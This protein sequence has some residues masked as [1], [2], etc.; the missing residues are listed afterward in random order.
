MDA[1]DERLH[2]ATRMSGRRGVVRV[3]EIHETAAADA[4]EHGVEIEPPV[5]VHAYLHDGCAPFAR[6]IAR[7]LECWRGGQEA[8]VRGRER[9][10]H[11]LENLAR[12]ASEGD[13]VRWHSDL[14]GY[15]RARVGHSAKRVPVRLGK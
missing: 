10:N 15:R 1:F 4:I 8:R 13:V 6:T 12:A 2:V 5:R 9:R 11:G 7:Q 14:R 3:A